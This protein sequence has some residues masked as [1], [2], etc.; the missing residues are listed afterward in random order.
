MTFPRHA[1]R[2]VQCALLC[3]MTMPL[4]HACDVT[5]WRS[6]IENAARLE[7]VNAALIRAVIEVE[8]NACERLEGKPIT[9]HAGAMGLMQ[10]LPA[11][12]SS[13]RDRLQLADDP[14]NADDN[15]LA[16]SAYLHDLIQELGLFDG[17]AAY[18]AGAKNIA[19]HRLDDEL[20]SSATMAYLRDVLE[21]VARET[22]RNTTTSS[23]LR[24]TSS[25]LFAIDESVDPRAIDTRQSSQSTLFAITHARKSDKSAARDRSEPVQ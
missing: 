5:Q 19:E 7:H 4:T 9:S 13:Y 11:T 20:P 8:S 25:Q 22:M 24:A 17:L 2:R 18:F 12:W 6:A 10:L 1:A 14:Y 16:G 23:P 3:V 21:F 15:I